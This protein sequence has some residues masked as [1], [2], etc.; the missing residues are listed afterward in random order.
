MDIQEEIRAAFERLS[1]EERAALLASLQAFQDKHLRVA[2]PHAFYRPSKHSSMTVEE[3]LKFEDQS[4]IRHEYVDGE[5]FAMSGTTKNHSRIIHSL[6]DAIA[7]RLQGGPCEAFTS[8]IKVRL[9]VDRKDFYYYPDLVV[10]CGQRGIDM[11]QVTDPTLIVEVLSPSTEATD[12]RE[13]ATNYRRIPSL[14]EYVLVS[15]RSYEVTIYRRAD[16]WVP[17]ILTEPDDVAEF[18]SIELPLPLAQIYAEV[19]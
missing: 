12:R 5:I 7:P 9:Q 13:K 14:E 17:E 11:N 4:Q 15:Q 1:A 2:E 16:H 8:D 18:R 3:Y 10:E 6:R 19:F